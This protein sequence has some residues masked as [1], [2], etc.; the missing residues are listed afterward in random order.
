ML[1]LL[2]TLSVLVVL[3]H[4]LGAQ[5]VEEP[6]VRE[7]GEAQVIGGSIDWTDNVL[8]VYGDGVAPEGVTDPVQGR[9]LGFRA[10]KAV[11]FR[12]LLEMVGQVQIDAETKV[13]MAMVASDTIRTQVSGIIRGAR[14]VPGSRR[15]V[16]GL[17]RIA[18]RLELLDEFADAVLPDQQ[19]ENPML[20]PPA[21]PLSVEPDSLDVLDAPD[22]LDAPVVFIPQEPYTGLLIDARGLDLQPSMAPR[23]L[24]EDKWEIYGAGFVER[25]YATRMGVVGYDKDWD[26]ARTSDRLG[27]E[28]ANPL[29]IKATDVAG[30]YDADVII[31]NEDGIRV[32]MADEEGDFLSQCRVMFVLGPEPVVVDSTLVDSV[33]FD[34]TFVDSTFLDSFERED[35]DF[36]GETGEGRQPE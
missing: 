29:I 20:L 15:E 1:R 13:S 17:Y 25:S 24:T 30:L 27:G 14:V 22:S 23:V 12:N 11:A 36:P 26:R 2:L 4:F 32:I 3:P 33:F 5:N 9:L 31:S 6:L 21:V 10:A 16:G 7:T 35:L 34:S 28:E 8:V 19:P 18:L